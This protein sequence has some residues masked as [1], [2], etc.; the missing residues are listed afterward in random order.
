MVSVYHISD[1]I[2]I[3]YSYTTYDPVKEKVPSTP[4]DTLAHLSG[5]PPHTNACLP[6]S[7][8]AHFI[9]VTTHLRRLKDASRH[10]ITCMVER[11][12]ITI[13]TNTR[14]RAAVSHQYIAGAKEAGVTV[15]AVHRH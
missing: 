7:D 13:I 11:E 14:C 10:R 2:S 15:V 6:R 5:I 1:N 3:K 4:E 12:D 9:A 8:L